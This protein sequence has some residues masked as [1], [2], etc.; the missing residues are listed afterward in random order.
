MS[1]GTTAVAA[2]HAMPSAE[3]LAA[4]RSDEDGLSSRDAAARLSQDGPNAVPEVPQRGVAVVFLRQF[5]S[6]LIYVLVLAAGLSAWLRDWADTA[7]I[8]AVLLINAGIG[9]AQEYRAERSARALRSMVRTVSDVVRDG[10]VVELDARD[11][12]VGDV[13]LLGSG[14]RVPADCRLLGTFGLRVDESP[15]TG[16]SLPVDKRADAAVPESSPLGDRPTMVFAGTLVSQGRGRAVV[17]A[18]G[19]ATALGALSGQLQEASLAEAPLITR[20][21]RFTVV[22]G[23]A[24]AFV[25]ALIG[26]LELARGAPWTEVVL[27]GVALAVSAIPEG[28]PVALT[29]T[30]AVAARRMA[31]RRVIVRRLVAIEALGSCT[32]IAT[33]K[34][35]TLTVNELTVTHVLVPGCDPWEV[36]GIGVEPTGTLLLPRDAGAPEL[37]A[38]ERLARAGALCNDATLART[39]TGWAHRGDAVDVAL[40]VLAHKLGITRPMALDTE[41]LLAAIPF[42]SEHRYAAT[43]HT[44]S[45]EVARIVV[46]GAP[47]QVLRMCTAMAGPD[48]ERP[49]EATRIGEQVEALA[50]DGERMLALATGTLP[51]QGGDLDHDDLAGLTLLGLV[52]MSDPPRADSAAAV[53]SCRRAGIA[54]SMVTGDHP[55]TALAVARELDLAGD[56]GEV[57]TGVQLAAATPDEIDALVARHR[58]FARVEPTQKYD[59]VASLIRQG[60][61][62]AV[63]GD[64]ANDAPALHHAHV[65]VAMGRDGT[66]VAREAAEIVVTDDHF[67]SISAGVEEGRVAYA[68]L[69]KVIQLLIST[70]AGELVLV[71]TA[72]LVGLPLPLLAAQLLWLNLVTNGIQDVALALEPAEGD[73]MSRPPRRPG[74]PVFDR[75]MVE[76]VL[77]S[78]VVMGGVALGA[79]HWML[80]A[81]WSVEAARNSIVLLMVL[82]EN[83]HVFNS[84]SELRSV[85][86]HDP[87]RNLV[88]VGGTLLAQLVHVAAMHLP[89]TQSVLGLSP[90]PFAQWLALLGLAM[91]L[92]LAV[93][94]HKGYRRR[95][96]AGHPAARASALS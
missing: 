3:V 61:V 92:L 17:T 82:F 51:R 79:Y 42:E 9:A 57:V 75:L 86:H 83:V 72:L 63:T 96:P 66:D 47:E 95:R 38:A 7:F 50:V 88:L 10:D 31:R 93:E 14:A 39:D 49:I 56:P 24:V 67:G 21:R 52:G 44:L 55:A 33:D 26:T 77:L 40:L 91:T 4:V 6:P 46:K 20:M 48:G 41:P 71:V 58:V 36:S 30:L 64:G 2:A 73:E 8:A 5:G 1:V 11:L 74:E 69:R 28:L 70:G 76:R 87:R 34:T 13:V 18:T 19:A 94:L 90:V 15:L 60:H 35:G 12:V 22:V 62:V 59:V 80:A 43:L 68:N 84:R 32:S 65:G 85:F 45:P 27:I 25:A 23:V 78:A 16:E 89:L 37:A 53:E 81:G 29:V 54:V